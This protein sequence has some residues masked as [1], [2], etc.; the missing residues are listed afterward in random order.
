MEDTDFPELLDAKNTHST[1]LKNRQNAIS[2]PKFVAP[3][4]L[5]NSRISCLV[6]QR[7]INRMVPRH[8]GQD[9]KSKQMGSVR[10]QS[11]EIRGQS[12]DDN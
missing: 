10:T 8:K 3:H 2:I 1:E 5:L 4:I 12:K 11:F 9:N 7:N 6:E